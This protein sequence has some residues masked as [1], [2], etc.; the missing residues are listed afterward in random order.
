VGAFA[1]K[2]AFD[3]PQAK[4]L[5]PAAEKG[6]RGGRKSRS[7]VILI[8]QPP[9]NVWFRSNVHVL[10]FLSIEGR[11]NPEI[12]LIADGH[13]IGRETI[14]GDMSYIVATTDTKLTEVNNWG[15]VRYTGSFPHAWE[16]FTKLVQI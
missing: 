10:F 15:N 8:Q 7:F 14:G 2:V 13:E 6:W 16:I 9:F 11:R 5:R 4:D 3:P 12:F 1:H